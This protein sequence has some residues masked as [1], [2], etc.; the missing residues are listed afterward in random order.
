MSFA[1]RNVAQIYL[2]FFFL[3]FLVTVSNSIV[4]KAS[5]ALVYTLESS[6]SSESL[7]DF[8]VPD[9][10]IPH[11]LFPILLDNSPKKTSKNSSTVPPPNPGDKFKL[12]S[13][14]V[15]V[16]KHL[17]NFRPQKVQRLQQNQRTV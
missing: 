15:P 4:T 12:K 6:G 5:P 16:N 7:K 1:V 13:I 10:Y 9:S 2:T 11:S 17:N 14:R 3:Y 8:T